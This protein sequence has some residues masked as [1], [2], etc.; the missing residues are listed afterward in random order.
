[1]LIN[2]NITVGGLRTSVRLEPEFW[3]ALWE[4]ADRERMSVDQVC[5]AIDRA[6][7][8]LS[9]TAAIRLFIVAYFDRARSHN[10]RR[11]VHEQGS[12]AIAGMFERRPYEPLSRVAGAR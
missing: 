3:D 2:R 5:T 12:R 6:A 7:G 10:V 9:R 11:M 8:D 1:M 4:I